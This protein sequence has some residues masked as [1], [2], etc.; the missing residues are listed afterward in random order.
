MPWK[1]LVVSAGAIGVLCVP[2]A[3]AAVI[4]GSAPVDWLGAPGSPLGRTMR[5]LIAFVASDRFTGTPVTAVTHMLLLAVF[6]TWA[7]AAVAFLYALVRDGRGGAAWSWGLLIGWLVVP[8]VLSYLV[9][10]HVEPLIGDR[11][12]LDVV[13]A[14]SMLS[15]VA[16]SRLRPI[17]VAL[18]AGAALVACRAIVLF[19]S[20]G[21]TIENWRGTVSAVVAASRPG[22]CV[23]F[24]VTD[25]YTPFDYYVLRLEGVHQP[26]PSPVLPTSSWASRTP[27]VID[28]ETIPPARMPAVAASCSRLW[29]VASHDLGRAPG[30]GVRPYRVLVYDDHNTLDAEVAAHYTPART[31]SFQGA[32]VQ[33]YNRKPSS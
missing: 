12:L 15:G 28:P 18:A 17:P 2:L 29:V 31:M 21:Q 27:H 9:S 6:A 1:P 19:P 25:G 13:P 30:P 22:D 5:Y 3:A 11:Y 26:V 24:F 8:I 16:C 33:L 23:A 14:A 4:R 20:Y 7:L 32:F 10:Q